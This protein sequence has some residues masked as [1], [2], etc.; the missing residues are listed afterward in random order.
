M[1]KV[2][3]VVVYGNH[4]VC[5]VTDVG[6]LSISQAGEE[7]LYYT[8]VPLYRKDALIYAPVENQKTVMRPAVSEEEAIGLIQEMPKIGFTEVSNEKERETTYKKAILSADLR[9]IVKVLKTIYQRRN[10]RLRSGKK[11]TMLDEKYFRMAENQLYEELAY[12]LGKD[13]QEIGEYI[14]ETMAERA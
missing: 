12:G 4:G 9:E 10:E 6:T 7:K 13:R 2:D 1:Y 14:E 8:L 5:K 3:D 11:V